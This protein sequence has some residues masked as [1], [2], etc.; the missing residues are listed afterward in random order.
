MNLVTKKET[1]TEGGD[2]ADASGLLVGLR[3]IC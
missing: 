1:E 2:L 3:A